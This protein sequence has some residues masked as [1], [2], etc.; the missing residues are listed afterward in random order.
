MHIEHI[1]LWARDIETLKGFYVRY[2]GACASD[3]YENP[4]KQYQSYFVTFADGA[5]LE[6]M[7]RADVFD[8][9]PAFPPQQFIGYAHL[10]IS[11]GTESAVDQLTAQLVADGHT[12]LSGPRHTGDGYYES[13]VLDPEG[14]LV[15]IC[16]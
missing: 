15:E 13:A 12:K 11:V 6:L 3:R 7:Q 2:F 8:R 9:P 10:A 5:R 14:N 4:L 16:V 1:A